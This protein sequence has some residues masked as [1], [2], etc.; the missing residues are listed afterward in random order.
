VSITGAASA[1][2]VVGGWDVRTTLTT[3]ARTATGS[4]TASATLQ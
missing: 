3:L 2:A 4:A 1:N